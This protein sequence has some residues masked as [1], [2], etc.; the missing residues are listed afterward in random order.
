[1]RLL[2]SCCFPGIGRDIAAV[3]V[4][5]EGG[6]RYRHQGEQGQAPPDGGDSRRHGDLREGA[7]MGFGE[8]AGRPDQF[9]SKMKVHFLRRRRSGA[10]PLSKAAPVVRCWRGTTCLCRCRS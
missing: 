10:G 2:H 6:Q 1:M 3:E 9:I 8:Q 4:F 7:V 5:A